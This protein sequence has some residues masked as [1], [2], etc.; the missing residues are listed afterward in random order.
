MF[1]RRLLRNTSFFTHTIRQIHTPHPLAF[2]PQKGLGQLFKPESLTN[3]YEHHNRLIE[4]LNALVADTEYEDDSLRV[5]I[6]KTAQLPEKAQLFNYASQIWNNDFFLQSLSDDSESQRDAVLTDRL[7]KEFGSQ[8][9]FDTQFINSALAIFGSGWTWLAETEYQVL[10]VI[11]SYNAG[12]VLDTTRT[13]ENDLNT[14]IPNP[15]A[16]AQLQPTKLNPLLSVCVWEHA[17]LR[18]HGIDGRERYLKAFLQHV[19]WGVVGKR[20]GL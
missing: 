6:Q 1:S 2:E 16:G 13:Q 18:D 7:K 3:F 14:S 19:N 11:N 17:Y 8:E 20:M 10:R 15:S 9:N 4:K 5:L 12:T